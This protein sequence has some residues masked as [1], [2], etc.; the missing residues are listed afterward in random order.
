MAD[1]TIKRGALTMTIKGASPLLVTQGNALM[2][3]SPKAP[4]VKAQPVTPR[5]RL[6]QSL[7]EKQAS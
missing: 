7:T 5:L 4:I 3:M 6:V 2:V 1:L